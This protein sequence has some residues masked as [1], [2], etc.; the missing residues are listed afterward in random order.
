MTNFFLLLSISNLYYT[1]LAHEKETHSSECC[2]YFLQGFIR[3]QKAKNICIK[4][5]AVSCCM[6]VCFMA[7][8]Q[9]TICNTIDVVTLFWKYVRMKF[10]L[11]KWGL[12]SP[13]GLLKFQRSI[14]GVK[15][16]CIGVFF[17]LL[18]S[19]WSA[20]VENELA[21]TIWIFEA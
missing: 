7:M 16:P 9:K 15:T 2:K 20:N 17:I 21:W 19:Y 1:C 18:E 6:L 8:A 13:P 10:T 12:E 3:K 14:T 4:Y 11:P 5:L